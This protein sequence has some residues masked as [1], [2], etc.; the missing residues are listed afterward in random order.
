MVGKRKQNEIGHYTKLRHVWWG[1][2]FPAGQIRYDN[3]F[4]LLKSVCKPKNNCQILEVGAGDGEF[5]RRLSNSKYKI[6]AIDITPAL[7]EKGKRIFKKLGVENVVL[8][9]GDAENL[10]FKNNS[11]DIVCGI[12]MLGHID[13]YKALSEA[14]RVLKTGGQIFFSEPNFY[15]PLIFLGLNLQFL[16]KRM[17]FSPDEKGISKM[18]MRTLLKEIGFSQVSVVNYDFLFPSTPKKF[19]GVVTQVSN[20]LEKIPIIKEISGSLIIWAKK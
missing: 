13:Y 4:K 3:R 10:D 7:I 5:T 16:R 19:V 6:T 12:S 11:Q 1:A 20:V 8:K 17:E 15:N 14:Y 9:V 2:L 18:K